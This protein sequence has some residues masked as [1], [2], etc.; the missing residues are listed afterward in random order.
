M[1]EVLS[2]SALTT[3]QDRGRFGAGK[4]GVG[5]AGAMDRLALACGNLL[6]GNSEGAA[7]VVKPAIPGQVA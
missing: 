3:I 4:W 6:L 5:I 1:M 2:R 7:A